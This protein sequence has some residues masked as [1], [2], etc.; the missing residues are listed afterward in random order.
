MVIPR[1]IRKRLGLHLGS[2]QELDLSGNA[3]ILRPVD[4]KQALTM[5]GGLYIHEGIPEY[6]TLSD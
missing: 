1:E 4:E 6:E 3:I 5:E 2:R